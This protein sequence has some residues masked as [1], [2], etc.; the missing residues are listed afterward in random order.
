MTDSNYRP[1][2]L[3]KEQISDVNEL[4]K[5]NK[6]LLN[7]YPEDFSL[8]INL[9]SLEG[10]LNQLLSE[11]ES[12]SESSMI[13]TYDMVFD[14]EILRGT[15]I[16]LAFFGEAI[17][18]YQ[19]LVEAIVQ[20]D[21][22]KEEIASRGPISNEIKMM[23]Q[24]NCEMTTASS[25]RIIISTNP[26]FD[27]APA[28]SALTRLNH[29]IECKDDIEKLKELKKVVGIR[30]IKRYKDFIQV[31]SLNK[32]NITFY[33]KIGKKYFSTTKLPKELSNNIYQVIK[34]VEE[35]P[36]QIETHLGKF[37]MIDIG[38]KKFRFELSDSEQI[39][40]SYIDT[41]DSRMRKAN[42]DD[43]INATFSHIIKYN[44]ITDNE[45]D[46]WELIKLE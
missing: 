4:I 20:K 19:V 34:K 29:L 5:I 11:F 17:S 16:P 10:Q 6:D 1:I 40:G 8:K 24:L 31:L 26:A 35:I 2:K 46:E 33:D 42:F 36:A 43:L 27:Q 30:V 15:S 41:L 32:A 23:S 37:T 25:F 12:S 45:A 39:T 7:Q 28:I 18:K 22:Q 44:D 21:V 9:E 14:G 38:Q 13:G 3:I